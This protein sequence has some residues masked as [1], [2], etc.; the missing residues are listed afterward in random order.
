MSEQEI[1]RNFCWPAFLQ[2]LIQPAPA[3]VSPT[4]AAVAREGIG[5]ST[6]GS[7]RQPSPTVERKNCYLCPRQTRP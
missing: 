6:F 5:P 1:E 4:L 2:R 3:G 7:D